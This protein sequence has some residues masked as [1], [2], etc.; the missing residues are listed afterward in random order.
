MYLKLENCVLTKNVSKKNILKFGED[1]KVN[2]IYYKL[3]F[4]NHF[5]CC[6]SNKTITAK[7]NN[8]R[9]IIT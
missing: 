4:Q 2:P 7:K 5:L 6:Q 3:S 8:P 9:L 1:R